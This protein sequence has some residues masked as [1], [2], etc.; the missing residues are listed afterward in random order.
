MLSA[1]VLLLG[2]CSPAAT[3]GTMPPP[4]L[5]GQ[6]DPS[7]VPDF[8]AVAGD[9]G[10]IAGYMPKEYLFPEQA[11]SGRP[12]DTDWPVFAEDLQS[13]IGHMVTGRGFVALGVDPATVPTFAV[14]TRPSL[15]APPG[16][17]TSLTLYV[18]NGTTQQAWFAVHPESAS[19]YNHGLGVGCFNAVA[20]EALVMLD[21]APQDA[22][23]QILLT[24]HRRTEAKEGPTLWV[25]VG[26]DGAISQGEG[27][28]EWWVGDPQVC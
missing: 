17:T 2:A 21:R 19:G 13:L 20:G 18:R 1:M 4:G 11:D 15:A 23:A 8:I 7:M 26:S 6:V 3:K 5:D 14:R 27:V 25:D 16:G 24:I 9:D 12:G 10:G 28:P 22:D